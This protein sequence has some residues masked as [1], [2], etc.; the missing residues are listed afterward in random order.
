MAIPRYVPAR[1]HVL[2]ARNATTGVVIR[3]GPSP[4]VCTVGWDRKTDTFALGQWFKG[5]I[6]ERR[7]DLSRDGQFLIYFAM[8][9]KWHGEAKGSWTAIAKAPYLKAVALWGKGDCWN[10]GGLFTDNRYF[11]LNEGHGPHEELLAP[12]GL[13]R[14]KIRPSPEY[15]GGECPGVYYIR[16]QR[17]GWKLASTRDDGKNSQI[18]VFEK[19]IGSG[20]VLRKLAHATLE[21]PVGKGCYFDTHEL[22]SPASG[23]QLEKANWEWAD[24]D[25][26]RLVWA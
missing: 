14:A 13:H 5:R 21:H 16:L 26:R 15:Y 4:Q 24:L 11:W 9:G 19:S 10:G 23:K 18:V 20:W 3:R 12:R 2:L 25:R 8:N 22:V 6:Y 1:L 7:S 17:D